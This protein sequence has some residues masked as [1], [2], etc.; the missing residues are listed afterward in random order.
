MAGMGTWGPGLWSDDAAADIK[1]LYREALEDGVD[2]DA[3]E[4]KVLAEFDDDLNDDYQ[5]SVVWL[6]L[7]VA[8]SKLGRLSD[9]AKTEAIDVIDS[10]ADLRRWEDA[11]AKIVAK[12]RGVLAKA[13]DQLTGEQPARKRVRKPKQTITPLKPGDVLAYRAASGRLHLLAV[14]ALNE[15]RLDVAPF[16]QLLDFEGT[17][18]PEPSRIAAMQMRKEGR[19]LKYGHRPPEPWSMVDGVVLAWPGRQHADAGFEIVARI[20]P[21]P[22]SEQQALSAQ[23]AG[24]AGWQNWADYLEDQDEFVDG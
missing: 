11:D 10:G 1:T 9:R 23:L 19:G 21:I 8:Q 24:R 12:R 6:A 2:D 20:E 13:R 18:V 17:E 16:V 14:R 4:A 22:E 15:T 7:A 3:A 5:R